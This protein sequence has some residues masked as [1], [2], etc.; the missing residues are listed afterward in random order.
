MRKSA[1]Y[2]LSGLLLSCVLSKPAHAFDTY[3]KGAKLP[4]EG[5]ILKNLKILLGSASKDSR[6]Q[7]VAQFILGTH[8]MTEKNKYQLYYCYDRPRK[9]YI[10]GARTNGGCFSDISLFRLNSNIWIMKNI[11]S[12]EWIIISNS[13]DLTQ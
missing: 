8:F 13:V 10:F 5:L 2:F 4:S 6:K 1:L 7:G 12:L 3:Y 11:V 9:D